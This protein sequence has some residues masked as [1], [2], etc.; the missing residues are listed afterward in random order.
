MLTQGE[1]R[2]LQSQGHHLVIN[3]DNPQN[4]T[5]LR[6]MYRTQLPAFFRRRVFGRWR[7]KV[8]QWDHW[9]AEEAA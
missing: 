7:H 5:E 6:A 9:D 1:A 4:R 3:N 8:S 2:V